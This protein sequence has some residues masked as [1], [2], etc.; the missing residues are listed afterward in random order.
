MT[1]KKIIHNKTFQR[2][3]CIIVGVR[4]HNGLGS[5]LVRALQVH[6]W[7]GEI[8][9]TNKRGGKRFERHRGRDIESENNKIKG[10]GKEEENEECE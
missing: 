8:G 1:I 9:T 7:E 2:R 6:E 5:I 3:P 10:E 4:H